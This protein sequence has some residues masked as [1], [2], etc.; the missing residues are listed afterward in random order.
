MNNTHD[1]L[2]HEY[3]YTSKI[4]DKIKKLSDEYAEKTF[5]D[6]LDKDK[7]LRSQIIVFEKKL[8]QANLSKD[9][10]NHYMKKKQI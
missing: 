1:F 2:N 5:S 10:T 9:I 6:Y 8:V 4:K 3:S 7:I